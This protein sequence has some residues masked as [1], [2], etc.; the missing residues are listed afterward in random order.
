MLT[1]EGE[2][3]MGTEQIMGKLSQLPGLQIDSNTAVFDFQ[4]SINDGIF[5]L[6]AGQ[7]SIDEGA[8]LKFTHSFL[9]QK[10]GVAG[11][12]VH[13]EVFRLNLG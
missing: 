5:V 12:Y 9:L 13:N 8:P 11:Y 7:L 3:F 1:Y 2:Q 6:C 10:G 4:P